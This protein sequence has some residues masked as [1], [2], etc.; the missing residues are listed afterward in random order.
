MKIK[1]KGQTYEVT[2]TPIESKCNAKVKNDST[3]ENYMIRNIGLFFNE[4]NLLNKKIYREDY[5]KFKKQFDKFDSLS[6]KKIT[7]LFAKF[8]ENNKLEFNSLNSNN[9]RSIVISN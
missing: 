8:A 5:D 1:I 6:T 2:L 3:Y 4:N 9:V 7:L